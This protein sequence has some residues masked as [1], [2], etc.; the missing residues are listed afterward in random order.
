MIK[1]K[2]IVEKS[3]AGD[4][5]TDALTKTLKGDTPGQGITAIGSKNKDRKES[6]EI[7]E[8]DL[9]ERPFGDDSVLKDMMPGMMRF[10]DRAVNAKRYKFAVRTFLDLRKKNPND[11]RNNLIKTSKI[12]DVDVRTLD[13]MFRDMVK[14][15]LMPKH[16]INYSPTFIEFV[17]DS[18]ITEKLKVSDGL[19]TWIKDFQ[20]SDAPQ[21]KNAD[22]EK[23]RDMAIAAFTAAGGKLDESSEAWEKDYDSAEISIRLY[24]DKPS[25]QE[26]TKQMKRVAGHEFGG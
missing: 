23:R 25:F 22:K 10:L 2:E 8:V 18:N 17:E 4:W 3:G 6:V 15:G 16:L 26:F 20:D 5:G 24:K 12:V 21:F 9:Q 11:A 14:K 7:S 1:F 19:G 13:R